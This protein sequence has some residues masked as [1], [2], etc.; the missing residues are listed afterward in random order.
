MNI[1]MTQSDIAIILA[2]NPRFREVAAKALASTETPLLDNLKKWIR[3]SFGSTSRIPAIKF[4]R[5]WAHDNN[6]PGLLGLADAKKFIDE[7]IPYDP[8]A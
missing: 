5:L 8:R 1:P 3:G 2:E 6:F 7:L 4:V